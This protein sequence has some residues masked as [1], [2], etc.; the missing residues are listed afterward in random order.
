M[1]I[2]KKMKKL[3]K[4]L[5]KNGED[6]NSIFSSLI[7]MGFEIDSEYSFDTDKV[8]YI[9]QILLNNKDGIIVSLNSVKSKENIIL[10]LQIMASFQFNNRN[11]DICSIVDVPSKKLLSQIKN[12]IIGHTNSHWTNV[13]EFDLLDMYDEMFFLSNCNDYKELN[14]SLSENKTYND[15]FSNDFYNLF[16]DRVQRAERIINRPMNVRTCFYIANS[17]N[18][19]DI[20]GISNNYKHCIESQLLYSDLCKKMNCFKEQFKVSIFN[21][22]KNSNNDDELS[23]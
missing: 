18:I 20:I 7:S 23:K 2:F 1:P 8:T 15:L 16:L 10:P 21:N 17:K 9:K 13:G 3:N 6:F 12:S 22:K 5:I 11:N 4:T 19:R 14:T